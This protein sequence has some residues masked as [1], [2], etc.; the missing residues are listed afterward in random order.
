MKKDKKRGKNMANIV[1]FRKTGWIIACALL[2]LLILMIVVVVWN[3][4]TSVEESIPEITMAPNIG[5]LE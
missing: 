2:A 1:K 5:M 3:G 4:G